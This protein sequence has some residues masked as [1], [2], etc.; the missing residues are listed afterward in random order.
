M[1]FAGP[2][3]EVGGREEGERAGIGGVYTIPLAMLNWIQPS[4]IHRVAV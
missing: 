2:A 4:N 1:K 3:G